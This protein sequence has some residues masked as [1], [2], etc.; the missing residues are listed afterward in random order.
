[1]GGG[2]A[3]VLFGKSGVSDASL[4]ILLAAGAVVGFVYSMI[5]DR[6][7]EQ[8]NQIIWLMLSFATFIFMFFGPDAKLVSY[9]GIMLFSFPISLIVEGVNYLI[10]AKPINDFMP[11]FWVAAFV[12][13]YIQWFVLI[14]CIR[15]KKH[16]GRSSL[17]CGIWRS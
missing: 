6:F 14:P 11:L 2:V 15:S 17:K 9:Y 12:L 10:F 5:L 13:G 7:K 16:K 3:V 8:T 4:G 1:M